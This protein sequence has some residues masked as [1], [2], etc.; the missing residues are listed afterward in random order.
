MSLDAPKAVPDIKSRIDNLTPKVSA[1]AEASAVFRESIRVPITTIAGTEQPK[2][3]QATAPKAETGVLG[4]LKEVGGALKE[5]ARAS[6]DGIANR[7]IASSSVR[8]LGGEIDGLKR[9]I[10]TFDKDA[11][12]SD[13]RGDR[14]QTIALRTKQMEALALI[15]TKAKERSTFAG[16]LQAHYES[17]LTAP[18]EERKK[19]GEEF[20][21]KNNEYK[22]YERINSERR[23]LF[24]ESNARLSTLI[25][26]GVSQDSEE[27]KKV[28]AQLRTLDEHMQKGEEAMGLAKQ[29]MDEHADRIGK[30]DSKNKKVMTRVNSWK[31]ISENGKHGT[32]V[33]TLSRQ[34]AID[35]A[36]NITAL[37]SREA[38]EAAK[39]PEAPTSTT[40]PESVPA[41][42]K[43]PE[44]L[45]EEEL[46]SA[47]AELLNQPEEFDFDKEMKKLVDSDLGKFVQMA[48]PNRNLADS[49]NRLARADKRYGE[50]ITEKQRV[51]LSTN[52]DGSMSIIDFGKQLKEQ[53]K[54]K[55]EMVIAGITMMARALKKSPGS[56]AA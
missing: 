14:T 28:F 27:M 30:W 43:V 11:L 53:F 10:D 37:P 45:T 9:Q 21:R 20:D 50:P 24:E 22:K 48:R 55:P 34:A 31:S 44:K 18:T 13:A 51:R 47:L 46:I 39:R 23:A 33:E 41:R 6:L 40:S 2:S 38:P 19:W 49:W 7:F 32:S 8:G 36:Q 17:K 1:P 12:A 56:L 29:Q 4:K 26:T 25:K 16:E 5:R 42:T 15:D 52:V 3:E 54:K 35:A